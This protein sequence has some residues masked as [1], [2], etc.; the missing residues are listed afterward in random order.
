M[1]Q[2]CLSFFPYVVFYAPYIALLAPLRMVMDVV[3]KVKTT[4]YKTEEGLIDRNKV[5]DNRTDT[6]RVQ[7]NR[8]VKN[9]MK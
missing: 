5:P 4:M 2:N 8:I 3:I 7:M 1:F 9:I 6:H